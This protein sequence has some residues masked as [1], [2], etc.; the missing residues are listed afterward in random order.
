MSFLFWF[1]EGISSNIALQTR[2]RLDSE[3]EYDGRLGLIR[4]TDTMGYGK[5][6]VVAM[7]VLTTSPENDNAI[8]WFAAIGVKDVPI[9][10]PAE[11]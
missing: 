8:V 1:S 3:P 9:L 10:I 2:N 5:K 7:H 6:L 4:R 11:G